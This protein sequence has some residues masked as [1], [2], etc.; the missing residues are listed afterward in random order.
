MKKLFIDLKNEIYLLWATIMI[1]TDI[2]R[3][4]HLSR[5]FPASALDEMLASATS[6]Y[7]ANSDSYRISVRNQ[8]VSWANKSL[9]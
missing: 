9:Y 5:G 1:A 4:H 6:M 7:V 2:F 8:C 3:D